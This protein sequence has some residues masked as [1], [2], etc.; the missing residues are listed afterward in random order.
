MLK[1]CLDDSRCVLDRCEEADWIGDLDAH[2][3]QYGSRI[4]PAQLTAHALKNAGAENELILF[5]ETAN[6]FD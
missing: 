1:R 3:I 4:W 6:S 2:R 5:G